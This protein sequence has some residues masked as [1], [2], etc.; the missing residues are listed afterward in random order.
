MTIN[1]TNEE[2]SELV[3][4]HLESMGIPGNFKLHFKSRNQG[5][6]DCSIQMVEASAADIIN[7]LI[8]NEFRP[9]NESLTDKQ[10]PDEQPEQEAEQL[11]EDISSLIK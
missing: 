6:C 9:E 7:E 11:D 10:Y 2:L 1:L 5:K 3:V 4:N 8:A